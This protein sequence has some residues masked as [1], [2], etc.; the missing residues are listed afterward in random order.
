MRFDAKT[1]I[2]TGAGSGIGEAAAERFA[3]EGGQVVLVGRTPAKLDA[4]VARIRAA[5]GVAEPFAMDVGQSQGW[6]ALRDQLHAAGRRVDVVV[7]NA[8]VLEKLPAHELTEDSWDWQLGVNLSSVYHS[9]RAFL[10]DLRAAHG[11]IVNVASVHGIISW[12]SHPAYGAAKGGM[13]AFTRQLAIEYGPQVRVN[14]VV[15]GPIL[16]PT[17]DTVTPDELAATAGE[18]A[19]GRLGEPSEVA[20]VIAFVASDEA[21]YVTGAQLVVDGGQTVKART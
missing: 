20:A 1:I 18:T 17:W 21:S 5:G 16:T 9:V 13:L 2:V 15:P 4:V 10:P 8:Y 3:A 12:K 14:A 19:L 7:N 6:Q 11:A